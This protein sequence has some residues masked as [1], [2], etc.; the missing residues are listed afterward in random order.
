MRSE[1]S[2]TRPVKFWVPLVFLLGLVAL[3]GWL[4][5]GQGR[6]HGAPARLSGQEPIAVNQ[7][8]PLQGALPS[9]NPASRIA[10]EE[11]LTMDPERS[12]QAV[13]PEALH[14]DWEGL[15]TEWFHLIE[16][17]AKGDF[18][19]LWKPF[20]PWKRVD[21]RPLRERVLASGLTAADLL[22]GERLESL[23]IA[24]EPSPREL[25]ATARV[26]SLF[27]PGFADKEARALCRTLA[28][29]AR[30]DA[31][32]FNWAD[33]DRGSALF[34]LLHRDRTDLALESY[35][36]MFVPFP[37]DFDHV[38]NP[39]EYLVFVFLGLTLEL[40][41][42]S[43]LFLV[44]PLLEFE[45]LSTSSLSLAWRHR[46]QIQGGFE[47]LETSARSLDRPSKIYLRAIVATTLPWTRGK[48]L[49]L[50]AE[51]PADETGD[52]VR[53]AVA[54]GL[55]S[56]GDSGSLIEFE[57]LFQAASDSGAQ[58]IESALR[59]DLTLPAAL[60]ALQ[61]LGSRVLDGAH[62]NSL[63][64]SLE[65]HVLPLSWSPLLAEQRAAALAAL[66]RAE[67]SFADD[68]E[69]LLRLD[70]LRSKIR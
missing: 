30:G 69:V 27:A 14:L 63:L 26:A 10:V 39:A 32:R 51:A 61:L 35:S 62:R 23:E 48:L 33:F 19:N 41:L 5:L 11:E 34:V 65:E 52:A 6:S 28:L 64:Q 29:G 38:A 60:H 22:D 56:L 42:G 58:S 53:G 49:E 57:D 54:C 31:N 15:L 8:A 68:P 47:S 59:A 44:D 1:P 37:A 40:E 36:E 12:G 16:T 25:R 24:G 7:P 3:G 21:L 66:D 20:S 2:V 43:P 55:L 17:H 13:H 67:F 4:V 50:V 46:I 9:P 70:S 45:R 18:R